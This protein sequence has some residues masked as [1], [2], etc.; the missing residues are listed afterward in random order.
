MRTAVTAA[1]SV[2]RAAA[3][4]QRGLAVEGLGATSIRHQRVWM[5]TQQGLL[6][7][8]GFASPSQPQTSRED[9]RKFAWA[10]TD[11]APPSPGRGIIGRSAN[12]DVT[13]SQNPIQRWHWLWK[14]LGF[15][16]EDDRLFR[17]STAVCQSCMNRTAR[18]E[19]YR[20]L[21][22]PRSFRAQQALLMA[23]VWLLHRRLTLE[24]EQ[25][26]IM[27]ELM[28]DRLWEETVVRI[29][30]MDISELTVNKHLAQVQ[31][32]CFNACIAYDQGLKNGPNVLQTAVAQHL[33]ENETPEGLRIASIV[34]DYMK[35]ELKNLE[36]VDAKY[37]MEGTIPWS[38]L[39]ETHAKVTDIPGDDD[40]AVLIGQRFGNWRSALDNRG[41]LYYWNMTT[42][43]SVWDRPT[44]D[45]LHEGEEQK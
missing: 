38:P 45:K 33:L 2:A 30:Y 8:R 23:H 12:V 31:Q 16:N 43:Y 34:A 27:Q 28:F 44:G 19:F 21:G 36:K 41:K 32:V 20:A 24:G 15:L 29:R 26:K 5:Q 14:A 1:R 42:R 3:C 22:L 35:R 10:E 39:P 18:P 6:L 7:A 40:N 11:I 37:I 17:H 13:K 4:S 25:G 9:T